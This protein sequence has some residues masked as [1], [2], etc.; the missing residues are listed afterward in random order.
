MLE[1]RFTEVT[2][3]HLL[4]VG[5]QKS[6]LRRHVSTKFQDLIGPLTAQRKLDAFAST[7]IAPLYPFEKA[8]VSREQ[9]AWVAACGVTCAVV[10][11]RRNHTKHVRK[12]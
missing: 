5:T 12:V 9:G 8:K 7:A 1:V 3:M 2:L 10:L 6:I 4:G 11:C